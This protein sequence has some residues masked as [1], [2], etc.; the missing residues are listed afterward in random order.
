MK[1]MGKT[2]FN[3]TLLTK[4]NISVQQQQKKCM[5]FLKKS[6]FLMDS[7]LEAGGK[8]RGEHFREADKTLK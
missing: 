5:A 7:K 2:I 8:G 1:N 6:G 3:I 4:E